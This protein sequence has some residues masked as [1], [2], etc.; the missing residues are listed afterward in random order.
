MRVFL[1][2]AAGSVQY[3]DADDVDLTDGYLTL[4]EEEVTVA[5]WAPGSWQRVEYR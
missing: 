1:D 4:S 3:P 2:G 5:I